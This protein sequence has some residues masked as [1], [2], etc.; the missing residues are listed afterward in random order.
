M[1]QADDSV[2]MPILEWVDAAVIMAYFATSLLSQP[3]AKTYALC[4]GTAAP[5]DGAS[6][7]AKLMPA[8]PV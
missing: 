6:L 2:W 8:V 7:N 1:V 3:N 5:V 4:L